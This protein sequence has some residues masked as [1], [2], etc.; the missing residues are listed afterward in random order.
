[1]V[2]VRTVTDALGRPV[3]LPHAPQRLVSLVPSITETLFCF[4]WG[5]QVVGITDYCTEPA[6]SV[7]GKTTIGGTKNPDVAKILALQ[8]HLVFAVAEENRRHDVEQLDAAGIPVYVFEPR[9]VR[10]GIDLLWRVA[11]L[12]CC[13]AEAAPLLQEIEHDYAETQASVSTRR[14]VRVFCPVWK[15][16]YMTINEETY[17]HDVLWVCGGDNLFAHRQRRFPLAADLGQQPEH[18]GGRYTEKDRR[19]PRVTLAEMASLRPEVI[20]L[21]DE[22]YV[23]TAADIADFASWPDVPAIQHGR[24]HLIDGKMVSWYGPRIG[25]SLRALRELLVA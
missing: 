15:D 2:T 1:M 25:H 10:D 6:A 9:T 14:R 20:L 16:P 19:Y 17:V 21:P 7:A 11:D 3:R 18:T 5:P 24:I 22:P 4:G 23:F 8:P 12:L 13:H